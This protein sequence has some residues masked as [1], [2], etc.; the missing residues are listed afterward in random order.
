MR[1]RVSIPKVEPTVMD[2]PDVCPYPD[3]DGRYFKIHQQHCHKPL[4][5]TKCSQVNAVRRACLRCKRTHRVYPKGVS[6]AHHSDRLKGLAALFYLL[7]LSYGGVEDA[8]V[9][10]E[11]P[12]GKTTIYR[13]V[14]ASGEQ[15]RKLRRAWLQQQAGKVRVVGGDPTRVRCG[16]KDVAVGVAVDDERGITLDIVLLE[17]EQTDTLKTWLLPILELVGAEVL[18]TD[19][20]D[21]FKA[22]ADEAGVRHQICRRHV[23]SNVLTF[24]AETAEQVWQHPPLAP[25]GL[26]V[27]PDQLLADLELLEWIMLGHPGHGAHLLEEMYL[28]YAR[29]PAPKKGECA[30]IW[31]RMRNHVLHLWNNWDRLTC[32]LTLRHGEGVEINATNNSS[33]RAIGWTVKERYRTMRGYKRPRSILNVTALTGWLLE[34]PVGYDMSPL[35]AV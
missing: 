33:E 5:D 16:G 23:T 6:R 10:L 21:G 31:Y 17:N 27:S 30:T 9:A 1:L 24:I 35:F 3:C 28:R 12:L 4:R 32:Y 19:D 29:A 8:L 11:S 18:T 20:A 15:V 13:D 2:A 34:Q 14:Q 22:V 7:G 25:E 26:T